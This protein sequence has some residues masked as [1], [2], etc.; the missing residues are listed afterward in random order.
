MSFFTKWSEAM[1]SQDIDAVAACIHADY[2]FIRHQSRTKM[3]K[4]EVLAMFTQ[5]FASGAVKMRD[6]RCLYENNEVMVEHS[7][8]DFP[9]G[10]IEAVLSFCRLKDGMMMEVE[11]G[12][13]LVKS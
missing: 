7:I 13:T 11:T 3:N 12:A 5:M 1:E 8:I 10:S 2:K 4:Q 6:H 9:D